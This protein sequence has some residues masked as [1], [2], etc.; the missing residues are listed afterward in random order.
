MKYY[1]DYK[2]LS[3]I[4]SFLAIAISVSG[5]TE[6][7]A[8]KAADELFARGK[9]VECIVEYEKVIEIN[10]DNLNAYLQRGLAFS[11]TNKY[12]FA[13]KDYTRVLELNPEVLLVKTNRGSAYMKMENYELALKDFN[14][15]LAGDPKNQ[16]AYNNRGWCKQH[17]GDHE[18]ACEDWKKS[19]KLGNGEAKIILK[20]SDC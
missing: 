8:M 2:K 11:L 1:L 10:P 19:K 18:G 15:V 3:L 6:E 9:Y 14:D 17:L 20:N 12:E 4:F 5:Q 13:I 16:E 7:K